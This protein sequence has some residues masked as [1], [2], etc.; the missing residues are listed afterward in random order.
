[1]VAAVLQCHESQFDLY[2]NTSKLN[3]EVPNPIDYY[4][5]TDGSVLQVLPNHL[6]LHENVQQQQQQPS[7]S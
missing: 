4:H 1:M 7:V 3:R 2:L 6:F 5:I